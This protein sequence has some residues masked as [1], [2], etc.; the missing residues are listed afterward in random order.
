MTPEPTSRPPRRPGRH[1]ALAVALGGAVAS[2]ASLGWMAESRA[3]APAVRAPAEQGVRWNE[4]KPAQQDALRPLQREWT[5]IDAQRKQ[6]W[7]ELSANLSKRPPD[8]QRRIQE[9]MAEWARLSPQERGQARMHFQEAKQLSPQERKARWDAYQALPPEQKE[10]LA[11]RVAPA[12]PA[13]V[14]PP[15]ANRSDAAAAQRKSNIVPNPAYSAAPKVVAPTVVQARPGA[16][17]TL[18]TKQPAPPSH[19]QTGLPKI[20]ATPEF[21]NKGTLLPRR[22]PQGAATRS[23]GAPPADPRSAQ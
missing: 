17:T 22:G 6:K 18:I 14:R 4:L 13:A 5:G 20:A 21:I 7:I 2:V 16:T 12:A 15:V 19:Q 9:R 8:E 3:Q 11:A 10:K 23:A 1:A